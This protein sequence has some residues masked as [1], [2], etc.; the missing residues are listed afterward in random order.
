M[1]WGLAIASFIATMAGSEIAR[2]EHQKTIKR[3][4]GQ[5]LFGIEER[6][7]KADR[8]LPPLFEQAA[9][10][11]GTEKE[12]PLFNAEDVKNLAT[13]K[14]TKARMTPD[15]TRGLKTGG[16]QSGRFTKLRSDRF[17]RARE[18][19]DLA[20]QAFSRF[21]S[22]GRVSQIRGQAPIDVAFGRAKIGDE[23]HADKFINDM[24]IA[25]IQPSSGTLAFADALRVIG[26]M[27]SMYNMGSSLGTEAANPYTEI[28]GPSFDSTAA[29]S[30]AGSAA[31]IGQPWYTEA[32]NAISSPFMSSTGPATSSATA[33][34]SATTFPAPVEGATTNMQDWWSNPMWPNPSPKVGNRM[35]N[36][37]SGGQSPAYTF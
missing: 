4:E 23:I 25:E 22:P 1:G 37:F 27:G 10:D 15:L 8:E 35:I 31:Q 24:R 36:R 26:F 20:D 12:K 7:R 14:Q 18:R 5:A 21:L 2:R 3:K 9:E 13:I 28:W 6:R 19:S 30:A 17:G 32:L 29:A 16:K 34:V 33:P 11:V